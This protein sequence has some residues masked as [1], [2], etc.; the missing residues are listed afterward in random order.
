M[1][2][3]PGDCPAGLRAAL[4][5]RDA[6]LGEL[7]R[8]GARAY[9]RA[10]SSEGALFL[11]W[12]AHAADRAVLAHEASTRDA[13]GAEGPL[14]SPPV[15]ARGEGWLLERAV[16]DG[17]LAGVAAIGAVVAAADELAGL[18]LPPL[19]GRR[20]RDPVAVA[21]RR[22]RSLRTPVGR[23]LLAARRL[24]ARSPLPEV[25]SHG[26]FHRG[27]LLL[28][29]GRPWVVDWELLA[30]RPACFDL[31]Q[32]WATLDDATDRERLLE[33]AVALVGEGRR[34]HVLELRYVLL[35]R[36]IVAKLAPTAA[37]HADPEGGQALVALLPEVRAA[38]RTSL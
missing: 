22:L 37:F 11:R 14:R 16:T 27:N 30:R 34:R 12:S 15:L 26:D 23:D 17:P 2:A 33:A 36:T 3:L 32:L 31:M 7:W 18:A 6:Q 10:D 25:T 24:L 8:E 38:A 28:D 5:A 20:A 21:R 13:V 29:A 4:S 19:T 1:S 35:V 9:G